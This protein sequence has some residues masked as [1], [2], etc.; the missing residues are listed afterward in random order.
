[1]TLAARPSRLVAL[2]DEL[3]PVRY[4][5]RC[6]EWWPMDAEFWVIQVRP[7]GMPNTSR[8]HRY[9]LKSPVTGYACRACRREQQSAHWHRR[10]VA[11]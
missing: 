4:C 1:M 5:R 7:V 6:D 11:A 3:G 2:D 9:T 8:G 10:T